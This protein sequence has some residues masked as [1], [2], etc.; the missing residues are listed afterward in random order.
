MT[1]SQIFFLQNIYG[2]KNLQYI[3]KTNFR[4]MFTLRLWCPSDILN[5]FH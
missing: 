3:I 4:K 5:I 2:C 1:F